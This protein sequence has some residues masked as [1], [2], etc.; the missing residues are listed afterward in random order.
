[1]LDLF[2]IL[3]NSL[4]SNC[5]DFYFYIINVTNYIE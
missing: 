1:M 2:I 5:Y 4:K 3:D